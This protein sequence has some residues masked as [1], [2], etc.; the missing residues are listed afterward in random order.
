MM[1]ATTETISF[2]LHV[3]ISWYRAHS[4]RR[5]DHSTFE[6]GSKPHL[7]L[8]ASSP[9]YP[10]ASSEPLI[11]GRLFPSSSCMLAFPTSR[12][13]CRALDL[14]ARFSSRQSCCHRPFLFFP[15]AKHRPVFPLPSSHKHF[16]VFLLLVAISVLMQPVHNIAWGIRRR[17]FKHSDFAIGFLFL[18]KFRS[19]RWAY[20]SYTPATVT[21][22]SCDSSRL[23]ALFPTSSL[24][25]SIYPF[26]Y[27]RN[28]VYSK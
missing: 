5:H 27:T 15:T 4:L 6:V 9:H 3:D 22:S 7:F 20:S 2:L 8:F 26:Q 13:R 12:R 16:L 11:G 14:G 17:F 21:L 28:I 1:Q 19:V 18:S 25:C 23:P 10:L 24:I